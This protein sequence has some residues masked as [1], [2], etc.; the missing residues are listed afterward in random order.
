MI[1]FICSLTV[2]QRLN[3]EQ[4]A[5]ESS[6]W[7]RAFTQLG[8]AEPDLIH[9]FN[10]ILVSEAKGPDEHAGHDSP[11]PPTQAKMSKLIESKLA[12]M[13]D[14]QWKVSLGKKTI[15]IRAQVDRILQIVIVAKDLGSSLA[16]MDPIHAG[17]PWAGVCVILPV[18]YSSCGTLIGSNVVLSCS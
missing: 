9:R 8:D 2:E 3:A 12:A 5:I 1:A 15:E 13:Q 6:I 10:S 17:I 14:R 18:G 16:S 7:E 4:P 11:T